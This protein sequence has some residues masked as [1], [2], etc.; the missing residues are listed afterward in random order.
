MTPAI[1]S[2]REAAEALRAHLAPTPLRR[3]EIGPDLP[4]Y[5]KME[6][7]QPTGS[8]KVRGALWRLLAGDIDEALIC[9]SSGNHGAAVAW[10]ARRLGVH[11]RVFVPVTAEPA[12]IDAIRRL[13]ADVRII[14]GDCVETE[15][16]A[17]ETA[18]R[19]GLPYVSPYNDPRVIAGQGTVA[20]EILSALP[21]LG[22]QPAVIYAALGGGG[23]TGGIGA[24]LA[25][26]CPD[27]ELVA[28][29]PAASPAMHRCM[30]AGRVIDVS[31]GPTLSDGTAGG[32][33]PGAI[34]LP[35]CQRTVH[36]SEL[37]SEREIAAAMR[38]FVSRT[39]TP[40]EGAAGVALAVAAREGL[41]DA[42]VVVCG[43]NIS[44]ER[45]DSVLN[46]R[47]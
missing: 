33:E 40:I 45:L 13:G 31:C 23:L 27:A 24:V 10:A 42:V 25:A 41:A 14:G 36:R 32:V 34:T 39:D 5:L 28:C 3:A 44:P 15:A 37:V 17:R 1:D 4:V 30:E 43:G 9:A 46:Q 22:P 21:P 29:S 19:G 8:F 38:D 16:L 7:L 35:L 6:N 2:V 12:K 26:C 11:A 20:L 47:A 18:R